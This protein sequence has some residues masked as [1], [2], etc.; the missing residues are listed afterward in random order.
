MKTVREKVTFF[1]SGC[2]YIVFN[3]RL[4]PTF[5]ETIVATGWQI[6]QTAPFIIGVTWVVVSFF[7][8]M[9]NGEKMP[10]DRRVRIFFA[11]GIMAGLFFA[12]YEY[13]G[14]TGT[15]AQ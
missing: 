9:A 14:V 7:Q 12:I 2:L 3:L 10:W 1:I 11:L 8:Y 5:M 4:A 13:A 15:A 6:L